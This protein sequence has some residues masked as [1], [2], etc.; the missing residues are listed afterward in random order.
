[1]N[2]KKRG[3]THQQKGWKNRTYNHN[4]IT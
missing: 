4:F 1:M 2:L 3:G